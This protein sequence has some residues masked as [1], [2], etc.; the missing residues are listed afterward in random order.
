M[1]DQQI[2]FIVEESLVEERTTA[3]G[4]RSSVDTGGTWGRN[5]S[6]SRVD[7]QLFSARRKRV[8]ISASTVKK[9]IQELRDVVHT[10]FVEDQRSGELHPQNELHLEEVALSVQVNAKGELSIFAVGGEI[11]GSGG[12]TLKFVRS[13]R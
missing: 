8:G 7:A 5:R 10:L 6:Q 9:Q 2:Y 1:S 3:I 13:K 12:I 11:G 4:E